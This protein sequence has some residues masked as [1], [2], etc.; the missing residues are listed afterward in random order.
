ML[1]LLPRVSGRIVEHNPRAMA[2]HVIQSTGAKTLCE[3]MLI[4]LS[5]TM[6]C[7]SWRATWTRSFR[8]PSI[9]LETPSLQGQR[10]TPA[11]SG[12]PNPCSSVL[13]TGSPWAVKTGRCYIRRRRACLRTRRRPRITRLMTANLGRT[14]R[15]LLLI[16]RRANRSTSSRCA[17]CV[18]SVFVCDIDSEGICCRSLSI[19]LLFSLFL[20]LN[21]FLYMLYVDQQDTH[22]AND[23]LRL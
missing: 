6:L 4:T 8:A 13:L 5:N 7:R 17:C 22:S 10:T 12:I 15:L 1:S 3:S 19:L 11:A 2:C 9:P 16:V 18:K 14:C 21:P 23:Q 20:R